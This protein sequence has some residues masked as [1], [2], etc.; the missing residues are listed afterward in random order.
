MKKILLL[1]AALMIACLAAGCGD[2]G[3]KESSS[4]PETKS[5]TISEAKE[6]SGVQGN[7][8]G[9]RILIAYFS[10][11]DENYRVGYIEKGN[12]RILA[13]M[14][15]EMTGG[16]L[17]EIKTVKSYPKE[18][19][20][21]IEEAKQ[22]KESNQRPEIAGKLPNVQDY[23]MIFLGYPI[24]WGDLPMGVYTFLE[25]EDF[26][27]KTIA[28]FCTH[29]GSGM[30]GTEVFVA[31][32]TKAKML[33]GLALEGTVAQNSRDKAKEE[34]SKWLQDIEAKQ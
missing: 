12:T 4:S 10:R 34:L 29:E 14:L 15:A 8:A 18:Y 19:D 11:A 21:A 2:N 32:A 1:I 20:T 25:K 17:F 13:E 28:P 26:T 9:K 23:D 7:L 27:G 16:E 6:S 3:G 30:A 33:P 22:E 5:A 24:W 31:E